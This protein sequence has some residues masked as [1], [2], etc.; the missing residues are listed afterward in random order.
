M[1]RNRQKSPWK[2]L[3]GEIERREETQ[4]PTETVSGKVK[5]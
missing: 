4:K 1:R 5:W 3:E 2:L